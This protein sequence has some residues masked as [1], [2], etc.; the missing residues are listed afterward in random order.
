MF[1]RGSMCLPCLSELRTEFRLKRVA[2]TSGQQ[3]FRKKM[4]FTHRGLSGPA[5]LQISSYWKP[6]TSVTIDLAPR[7]EFTAPLPARPPLNLACS[8]RESVMVSQLVINKS[9]NCDCSGITGKSEAIKAG[10]KRSQL[11]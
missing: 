11:T 7:Q 6:S 2:T 1:R 9:P 10:G 8:A 4:L 5:I 3:R